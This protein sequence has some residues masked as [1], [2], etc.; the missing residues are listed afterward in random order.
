MRTR[1]CNLFIATENTQQVYFRHRVEQIINPI[2]LKLNIRFYNMPMPISQNK[3][4]LDNE[5]IS[6]LE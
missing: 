3:K 4:L 2:K 1:Y 6:V 5:A